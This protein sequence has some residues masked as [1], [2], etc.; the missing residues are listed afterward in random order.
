M[1]AKR[2][3][4]GTSGGGSAGGG[5]SACPVGGGMGRRVI[6]GG[7]GDVAPGCT[8]G[9]LASGGGV[10]S[11]EASLTEGARVV[12]AGAMSP[13]DGVWSV[14]SNPTHR[15]GPYP[16]HSKSTEESSDAG[17]QSQSIAW[18]RWSGEISNSAQYARM[19]CRG[20]RVGWPILSFQRL[21]HL[22][23][24]ADF[25]LSD[26][27]LLCFSTKIAMASMSQLEASWPVRLHAAQITFGRKG[28]RRWSGRTGRPGAGLYD[29]VPRSP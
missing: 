8:S 16:S 27:E 12:E 24:I 22:S 26:R 2:E 9:V 5:A 3:P 20:V 6:L 10:N 17:Q 13:G 15:V 4:T 19:T 23:S 29:R 18:A 1:W 7:S 14:W 21:I 11:F 28:R 25:S